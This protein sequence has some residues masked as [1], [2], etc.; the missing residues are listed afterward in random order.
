MSVKDYFKEKRYLFL[1]F[2]VT[3]VFCFVIYWAN[4]EAANSSL[5]YMLQ[6][7]IVFFIIYSVIDFF[8]LRSRI[9]HMKQ[10]VQN[11]AAD[12]M[13]FS[14]PSDSIYAQEVSSLA[15]KFNTYRLK[16]EDQYADELDFVTKWVHD[17]KVPISALYL[18]IDNM[19][20][21]NAAAFEMQTA[22]IE[23]HTQ[24]VLYHIKSKSFHDDYK[25]SKVSTK[26]IVAAALKQYATFFYYK[27]IALDLHE[28][29]YSVLTDEKWSGYIISQLLSNAVKHT[30]ENGTI[31]IRTFAEDN[32]IFICVRNTG[33]GIETKNL[34]QIFKKGYTSYME[35]GGS[36]STGY[37]LYLAKKLAERMG[38]ELY[39]VSKADEYAEFCLCFSRCSDNIS[40]M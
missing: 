29:D 40:K 23:Q 27:K 12:N 6:G 15:S 11:G 1:F 9:R 19:E 35:R 8:L 26:A 32:R 28:D 30:P 38:H 16:I 33:S 3:V 21:D 14:Y 5:F 20:D 10:F 7:F 24:K 4:G 34:N 18:L 2:F 36:G 39:A 25:I 17:I 22:Y 37:G 13:E 31:S